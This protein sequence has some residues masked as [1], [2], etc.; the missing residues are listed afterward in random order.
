MAALPDD[1]HWMIGFRVVLGEQPDTQPLPPSVPPAYAV[2][3]SLTVP[4]DIGKGPDPAIPYFAEPKVY[5]KVEPSVR[6]PFYGHN[7]FPCVAEAPNGDL[8]AVWF[9]TN[10]E[11]GREMKLVASRLRYGSG[12]W[13]EG[14]VFWDAPDR[15]MTGGALWN[16]GR[17][18]LYHVCGMGTAGTWGALVQAVRT[19]EDS[20]AT[21][22]KARLMTLNHGVR[23]MPIPSMFRTH[24]CSLVLS[25]DAETGNG[26]GSAVWISDDEGDSWYDAGG[27]IAGIH[28]PVA[29]LADG[30]LLAYGRGDDIY[31]RMP[32]SVSADK[33]KSWAYSESEF[34]PISL[35]QRAVL[36]RLQEGP[37]FFASFAN[38]MQLRDRSGAVRSVSG[39]FAA[40]SYDEGE[41]WTCKRLVSTDEVG[42]VWN[43]GAWTGEFRMDRSHAE[44][45]GYLAVTQAGSGVIHLLS[46]RIHY[47]FNLA[48]IEQLSPALD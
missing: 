8:L 13:D 27:L 25:C 20:G 3:V 14:S 45:K 11:S 37:L 26:G 43:G 19:S 42:G 30:R 28:A 46:S 23:T 21:W 33:G 29:E 31:G 38:G 6:G 35:G 9:T 18:K 5:V 39:L 22:S 44:P 10:E 41:S 36:R 17:G 12:S 32:K 24:D 4:A 2:S 48:W 15:N 47:A 16:D 7:H 40:V 1:K 34:D